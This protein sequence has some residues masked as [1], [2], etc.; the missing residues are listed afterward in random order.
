MPNQPAE[1]QVSPKVRMPRELWEN[2][3]AVTS[4]QG[5]DRA[6]VIKAFLRWYTGEPKAELP[7]PA[8]REPGGDRD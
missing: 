7:A 4:A 2:A 8:V 5:T 3:G 1:G 6:T